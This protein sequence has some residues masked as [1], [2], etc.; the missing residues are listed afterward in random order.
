MVRL[1]LGQRNVHYFQ[2]PQTLFV[3]NALRKEGGRFF[4]LNSRILHRKLN[5]TLSFTAVNQ[6]WEKEGDDRIS[7]FRAPDA[8]QGEL[9][10]MKLVSFTFN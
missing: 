3:L 7:F 9:W 6:T 4:R 5:S 10:L 8:G 2:F 1:Y